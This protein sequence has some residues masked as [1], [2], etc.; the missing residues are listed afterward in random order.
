MIFKHHTDED[1][2]PGCEDRLRFGHPEIQRFFRYFKEIHPDLHCSWVYRDQQS[3]D[4]AF[5]GGYSK[6]KFPQ[7]K[8]NLAPSQAVDI[9]QI[10]E[11]GKAVFDGVFC[12]KI[13]K[14]AQVSGFKLRW[15][16]EFRSLGDY[17]HFELLQESS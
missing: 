8:H 11:N 12:A 5:D 17:G 1:M 2:C 14:E 6:L 13:N 16:G 15:G 3:Q 4:E 10:N 7:S 9:F